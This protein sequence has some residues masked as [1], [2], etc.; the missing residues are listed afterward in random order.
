MADGIGNA[1]RQN[2]RHPGTNANDLDMVDLP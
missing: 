2:D 1:I